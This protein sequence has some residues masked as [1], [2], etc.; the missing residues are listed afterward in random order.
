[1][2]LYG[3]EFSEMGIFAKNEGEISVVVFLCKTNKQAYVHILC[4][5][6]F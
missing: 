3:I 2:L 5:I 6:Y 1:M 4:S